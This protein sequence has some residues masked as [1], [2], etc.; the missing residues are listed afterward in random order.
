MEDILGIGIGYVAILMPVLLIGVIFF[1]NTKNEKN[2]Y[3]AMIEI[4]QNI[5][6][7]SELRELLENLQGKKQPIDYRRSG[8][9]TL[10]IGLG[11]FLFGMSVSGGIVPGIGLLVGAIGAGSIVAGYLYPNDSAE[12]TKAVEKFEE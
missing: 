5:Q 6:D 10:F 3:D 1:F 9:I 12:L 7:P 4:S 8:V 2:K 11:I